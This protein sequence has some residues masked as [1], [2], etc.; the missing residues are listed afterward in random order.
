MRG[1][2][3]RAALLARA[4][5]KRG[6]AA[7]RPASR[8][9]RQRQRQWRKVPQPYQACLLACRLALCSA[10]RG[11]H[12]RALQKLGE[13]PFVP[14]ERFRLQ[15]CASGARRAARRCS[16]LWP[17]A[18]LAGLHGRACIPPP[19]LASGRCCS[20]AAP[21]SSRCAGVASLHPA[22]ADR[23]P[24]V[25]LAAA[26]ALAASG[27]RE[28]LGTVVAFASAVPNRISQAVYQ[29]LNQLVAE[30]L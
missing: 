2:D 15:L 27:K 13:L 16:G 1:G 19:L 24:A 25:L 10:R 26:S 21:A 3:G 12:T 23:L 30:C 17:A 5:R 22:V 9:Q 4:T 18:V 20:S 14:T 6:N 11:D 29:R 8:R 28:Q 7:C